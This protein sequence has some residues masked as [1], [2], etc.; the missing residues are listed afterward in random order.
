MNILVVNLILFT[1][2]KGVIPRMTTIKDTMIHSLCSGLVKTGNKVTLAASEEYRPT[3]NETY[4][5]DLKFFKSKLPSLF[6]PSL[7]PYPEGLKEFLSEHGK[8]YDLIISSEVFSMATL[9]ASRVYP[10]KL[11]VWQEMS[12]HQRKFFKL[13]SKFWH[14]FVLK[15]FMNKVKLIVPRSD[16]AKEFIK[17]YSSAV[18]DD[19]VEHGIDIDKFQ[20]SDSKKRQFISSSQLIY[21]KNVEGIIFKFKQFHDIPEY[22]DVKLL[23][24]GR[25]EMESK[26]KSMVED[27]NLSE[28][29]TFLGFIPQKELNVHIRESMGFLINTRQDL[30]IVSIPESIVSGTPVITNSVPSSVNYIK[31][32]KLGIVNDDWGAEELAAVVDNNEDYVEACKKY[33]NEL[34]NIGVAQKFMRMWSKIN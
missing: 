6:K 26:L 5:F 9:I 16:Y 10:E 29:V 33:R 28:C 11:I 14:N 3:S 8:N 2:E 4:D 15:N 24:A 18:S 31:D 27:L 22:A 7:I 13:P 12:M 1:P 23:I 17:K 25:G 20:F 19:I 34:T 21:R 32:N 30:N